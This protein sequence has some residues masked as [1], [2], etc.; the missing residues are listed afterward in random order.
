MNTR[1]RSSARQYVGKQE[2]IFFATPLHALL[3]DIKS[4]W[5]TRFHG[6][7][8]IEKSDSSAARKVM[9]LARRLLCKKNLFA[10]NKIIWAGRRVLIQKHFSGSADKKFWECG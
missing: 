1:A 3:V 8:V 6:V 10:G 4:I 9:R 5:F 2:N 7:M